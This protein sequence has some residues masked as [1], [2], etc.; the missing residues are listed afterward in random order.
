[1]CDWRRGGGAVEVR[2]CDGIAGSTRSVR[3]LLGTAS[4]DDELERA[5]EDEL[6]DSRAMV[7]LER[8]NKSPFP[9]YRRPTSNVAAVPAGGG[10]GGRG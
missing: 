5:E 6:R 9:H 10:H 3:A 4:E 1:M 2:P 8:C 7:T